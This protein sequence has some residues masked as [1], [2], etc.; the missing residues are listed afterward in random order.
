MI[1][2]NE[3]LPQRIIL[4][5]EDVDAHEFKRN[6]LGSLQ[7]I[8][9][10]VSVMAR[11]DVMTVDMAQA[12]RDLQVSIAHFSDEETARLRQLDEVEDIVDD[13]DVFAYR[14]PFGLG[15][16]LPVS[17]RGR[18][19]TW[20]RMN[21]RSLRR[22]R[23][24]IRSLR[25]TRRTTPRRCQ[26]W[27]CRCSARSSPRSRMTSRS[28][29]WGRRT[30]LPPWFLTV[31]S[32]LQR[33]ARTCCGRWRLASAALLRAARSAMNGSDSCCGRSTR[34]SAPRRKRMR[35]IAS[36]RACV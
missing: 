15:D 3:E 31:R 8:E 21:W 30:E 20:T 2:T 24:A 6:E 25:T 23:S 9:D 16:E 33:G 4:L 1:S 27:I 18:C 35:V 28:G 17:S 12:N 14:E 10:A 5:R 34:G 7:A 22:R 19:S 32:W 13:V 11:D 26:R 29:T 36:C